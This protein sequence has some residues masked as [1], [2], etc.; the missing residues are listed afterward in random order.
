M[1]NLLVI[2]STIGLGFSSLYAGTVDPSLEFA[3]HQEYTS[4]RAMAMGNAF[5][6]VVDDHSAIFYNPAVLGMRKEGTF[7]GFLKF[8]LSDNYYKLVNDIDKASKKTESESLDDIKTILQKNRGD[9]FYSKSSLGGAWVR[10]NWGIAFIPFDL[11]TDLSIHKQ[12]LEALNVNAYLDTTIAYSYAQKA[13]K[14]SQYYGDFYWE[15][16]QRSFIE[17]FIVIC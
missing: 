4:T 12:G 5:T 9:S 14:I 8:G 16:R 6:A 10:P 15:R 17:Y 11:K 2:F 1:K 7:R 3:I 13:K